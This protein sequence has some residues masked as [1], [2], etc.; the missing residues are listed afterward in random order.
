MAEKSK[1][2]TLAAGPKTFLGTSNFGNTNVNGTLNVTGKLTIQQE[3]TIGA[4][5]KDAVTGNQIHNLK[6]ELERSI[7]S[8]GSNATEQIEAAKTELKEKITGVESAYKKADTTLDGKISALSSTLEGKQINV[9]G[10]SGDG[11]TVTGANGGLRFVGGSNINTTV[12]NNGDITIALE[13]NVTVS[14]L[15]INGDL[16]VT[17]TT[18]TVNSQ[19]LVIKDN[20]ITL[21]SG[22]EG[23]GVTKGIAG[24]EINRGSEAKYQIIFDENSDKLKAGVEGGTK[25]LATEEFVTEAVSNATAA[26]SEQLVNGQW[27]VTVEDGCL[28]IKYGNKLLA[29]WD[30]PVEQ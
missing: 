4:E 9:T 22:D 26:G 27:K 30:A 28:V 8:A 20:M 3:G 19:D 14:G 2:A 17:G 23:A 21:N 12:A 1:V 7:A 24:I 29:S 25:A 11:Y 15:T 13:D 16:N 6:T 5:S 18:T 10:D